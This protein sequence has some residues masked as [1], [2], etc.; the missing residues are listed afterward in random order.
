MNAKFTAKVEEY[1]QASAELAQEEQHQQ[2]APVHLALVMFED[3]AGIARQAAVKGYGDDTYKSVCRVLRKR[4]VRL[5]KIDPAPD[6]VYPSKDF[7]ALLKKAQKMQKERQDSYL[8]VDILLMALLSDSDIAA[9]LGE[10]GITKTVLENALK[11]VRPH[12]SNRL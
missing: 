9:A 1:L 3:A 11:E 8:G 4:L 5:P 10:S 2:L 7:S 6:D 12:V